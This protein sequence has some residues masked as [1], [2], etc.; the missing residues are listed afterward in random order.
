M[1]EYIG[2][3]NTT[4][5]TMIFVV[6]NVF[7]KGI[8][9]STTKENILKMMPEIYENA[10]EEKII[11]LLPYKSYKALEE[12]IKYIKTENDIKKFFY[13]LEYTGVKYLEEAMIIIMR[14][15]HLEYN[16]SLNP[17]VIEKLTK[18]YTKESAKIAERYGKIERLTMGILYTYGVVDFDFLRE[19]ICKCM[20]ETITEEELEDLYFKRLNLNIDVDYY[21]IKWTNTNQTQSFV[22]YLN[23]EW[24]EID[25]G[26]IATEQKGRGLKYKI[27][28]ESELLKREEYLWND[29][30]QKLFEFMKSTNDDIY[31]LTIERIM[32]KSELGENI[33]NK[34][35]EKCRFKDD[36]EVERFMQLYMKWY[37]NNPQYPLCGYS[38][39][40]LVK[41]MK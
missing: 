37:N 34:L 40:E 27:F 31:Q 6:N 25:V 19:Q 24:D 38:P 23:E 26:D 8:K 18:I 5:D 3:I 29:D 7:E 12:L 9:E 10:D 39:N 16:Y 14:A 15:K 17:G 36:N 1:G 32:K 30:A 20:N 28:K 35:I 21:D 13:E 22:T 11:K 33:L 41:M 2:R 4:K